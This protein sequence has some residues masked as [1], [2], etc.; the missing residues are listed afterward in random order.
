MCT[1]LTTTC[2]S[3]QAFAAF[4]KDNTSRIP[5]LE[6]RRV[7]DLFCLKLSDSQWKHIQPKLN[8]T[9]DRVNYCLFLD[10]Y[11]MSEQEVGI[12]STLI[13][14][15]KIIDMCFTNALCSVGFNYQVVIQNKTL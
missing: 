2:I 4:D 7:L 5:V 14:S 6:F 3:L 8:I 10:N 15:K 11:T 9:G 12:H 1:S 13:G